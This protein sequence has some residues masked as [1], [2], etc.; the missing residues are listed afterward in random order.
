MKVILRRS[1][2][3][4]SLSVHFYLQAEGVALDVPPQTHS[5]PLAQGQAAGEAVSNPQQPGVQ[6]PLVPLQAQLWLGGVSRAVGEGRPGTR[7]QHAD[8]HAD[9]QAGE[10]QYGGPF[11]QSPVVLAALQHGL[12]VPQEV[13]QPWG[14][15]RSSVDLHRC[16][17]SRETKTSFRYFLKLKLSVCILLLTL[18]IVKVV[19]AFR[20][21]QQ[22]KLRSTADGVIVKLL[23]ILFLSLS[24]RAPSSK[25]HSCQFTGEKS[26]LKW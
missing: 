21:K 26:D 10:L 25:R 15:R 4:R 1:F 2:V 23:S 7:D 3:P 9:G 19:L 20:E 5:V 24:K 16:A 17:R 6:R 12:D 18:L 13:A 11:L 22:Q 8:V 14:T